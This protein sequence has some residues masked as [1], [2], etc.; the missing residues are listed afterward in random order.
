M[1]LLTLHVDDVF[2]LLPCFPSLGFDCPA[3]GNAYT[4][5]FDVAGT[6][7]THLKLTIGDVKYDMDVPFPGSD[8]FTTRGVDGT[9]GPLEFINGKLLG[10]LV[11]GGD[12]PFVDFPPITADGRFS[13]FDGVT[14]FSGPY[15]VAAVSEPATVLLLAAALVAA[16]LRR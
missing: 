5:T 7:V 13:A 9:F 11:G 15:D 4:G 2:N 12:I 14:A 6:V 10:G 8:L 16:C 3:V 1:Y